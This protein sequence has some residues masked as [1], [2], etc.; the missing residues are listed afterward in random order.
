MTGS[1]FLHKHPA[2]AGLFNW[3]ITKKCAII[4]K[5]VRRII[6]VYCGDLSFR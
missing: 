5:K 3:I 2:P 1:R 4:Y 6:Y